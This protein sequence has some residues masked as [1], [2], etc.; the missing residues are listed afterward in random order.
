MEKGYHAA[1]S[2]DGFDLE[3]AFPCVICICIFHMVLSFVMRLAWIRD[4]WY[5]VLVNAVAVTWA[6]AAVIAV[7]C[8]FV[9]TLSLLTRR[10]RIHHEETKSIE[11]ALSI[12]LCKG[13]NGGDDRQ[14]Q[15][16]NSTG[17]S[18]ADVIM[19]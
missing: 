8:V 12:P 5:W 1:L 16:T 6:I 3:D 19:V 11:S 10:L 18:I 13:Q 7:A 15:D 2:K 4:D 9:Y 17:S 14:E